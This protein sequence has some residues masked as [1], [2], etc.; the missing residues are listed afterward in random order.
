[1][2]K[3]GTAKSRPSLLWSLTMHILVFGGTGKT[4]APAVKRL[5]EKG[6]AVRV[7][8]RAPAKVVAGATPVTGDLDKPETLT[9]VFAGVDAVLMVLMVN[10]AEQA[11]GL[12]IVA[13]ATTAGVKRIGL[14]SLVHGEGTEV[15]PFYAS[16]KVIEAAMRES[17]LEWTVVRSAGFF[18]TDAGLKGD[19]VDKGIFSPPLGS[20][21]IN[22]IDTRD[23]GYA[24]AEALTRTPFVSGEHRI[25][26]PET[27]TGD[28]C[29]ATYAKLLGR[30][31][32]YIGDDLDAWAAFK[33][34]G[35]PPWSLNALRHMYAATQKIGMKPE[36]GEAK[37]AVLPPQQITFE[38]FARELVAGWQK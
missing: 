26:G 4:G 8:T 16:K 17:G 34:D 32:R 1:M 5:I 19:I 35:F 20:C 7:F 13:A 24:L 37:S 9:S 12:A 36:L 10:P 31:V 23:V 11:R 21:G 6:H 15:V 14:L 25:F 28:I 2:P 3:G 38:D 18:Q 29:A 30:P 22:R 27:L 33:K